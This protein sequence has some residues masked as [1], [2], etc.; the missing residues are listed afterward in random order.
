MLTND[1]YL[2]IINYVKDRI[3]TDVKTNNAT[4][5]LCNQILLIKWWSFG[6][7]RDRRVDGELLNGLHVKLS[8]I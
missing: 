3:A 7:K 6:E 1:S 4:L 2:F 8:D 5:N